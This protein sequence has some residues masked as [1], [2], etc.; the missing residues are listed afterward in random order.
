MDPD[1]CAGP[2]T[3]RSGGWVNYVARGWVNY[4]T[5]GWVNYLTRPGSI[6]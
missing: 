3:A 4:L 2:P 5:L 6:T 1:P